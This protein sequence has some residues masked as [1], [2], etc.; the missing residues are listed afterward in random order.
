MCVCMQTS[1]F[2]GKEPILWY[3]A[4]SQLLESHHCWCLPLAPLLEGK[5]LTGLLVL[6]SRNNTL[7]FLMN[8]PNCSHLLRGSKDNLWMLYINQEFNISTFNQLIYLFI[9]LKSWPSYGFAY[10]A[11]HVRGLKRCRDH[12]SCSAE[13]LMNFLL[14]GTCSFLQWW[15]RRDEG[16]CS[17]TSPWP[18]SVS[19]VPPRGTVH[20]IVYQ[21]GTNFRR[22]IQERC[23]SLLTKIQLQLQSCPSSLPSRAISSK[24]SYLLVVE[25]PESLCWPMAL[26]KE[27]LK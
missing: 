21:T 7:Q 10:S 14:S 25:G 22:R 13:A 5:R 8:M 24:L 6:R 17:S 3:G 16:I 11:A 23:N 4:H 15:E 1:G 19:S 20:C 27:A 26:Q 2:P 9:L 12:D 18:L